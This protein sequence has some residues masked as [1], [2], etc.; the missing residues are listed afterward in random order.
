MRN[1]LIGLAI[2]GALASGVAR[3][4]TCPPPGY[5]L[6]D[7]SCN[8]V[9]APGGIAGGAAGRV[10]RTVLLAVRAGVAGRLAPPDALGGTVVLRGSRPAN[11]NPWQPVPGGGGEGYGPP[12]NG[13]P[14]AVPPGIGWDNEFDTVGF[15]RSGLDP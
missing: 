1:R 4:Q 7:S 10:S 3:A 6:Q 11:P 9:S 15:D 14:V 2:F 12:D 5:M 8:A 13:P